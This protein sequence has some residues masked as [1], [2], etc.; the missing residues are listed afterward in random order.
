MCK[1]IHFCQV[2]GKAYGIEKHHVV[3]RS[4]A[5][6]M[7]KIK[8]NLIYLCTEHHKGNNGPHKNRKIDLGYKKALQSKYYEMLPKSHYTVEKL[9]EVLECSI[10]QAA[11]ICKV[12]KLEKEG[13]SK[14]QI[15]FRM[16]GE[17]F[18]E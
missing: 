15:V 3:F 2:C 13:Y 6:Y 5:S 16:M 12:I 7:V 1:E 8:Q 18:Y 17:K 4:Q 9:A 14:E 10:P 11:H